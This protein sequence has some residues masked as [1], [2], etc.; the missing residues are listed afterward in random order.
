MV[1]KLVYFLFRNKNYRLRSILLKLITRYEGGEMYSKTL[2]KIFS[3]FYDIEIG[4]YSYGCFH[5]ENFPPKT[6]IGRYCS[7]ARNVQITVGNHPLKFKS[8]HPFFF[9]P[10]FGYVKELLIDRTKINI[11]NDVWFGKSSIVLPSVKNICNG[12]VIGGGSVVT[13]DV[14]PYAV[15]AGNPAKII[16]YRFTPNK[17]DELLSD[18]WWEKDINDL[19]SDPGSSKRFTS[20]F[21]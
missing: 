21:Y 10:T 19:M 5:P 12:A 8:L 16:K 4:M 9:N 6:R 18:K 7:F 17:V 14:P 11:E 1:D 2:R 20:P 15:V 13:K 3:N